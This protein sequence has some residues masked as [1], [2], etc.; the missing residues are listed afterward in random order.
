MKFSVI[1]RGAESELREGTGAQIGRG[2]DGREEE[3]VEVRV[4]W[5]RARCFLAGVVRGITK[6]RDT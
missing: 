1:H 4:V 2:V 6:Q 3:P 5:G